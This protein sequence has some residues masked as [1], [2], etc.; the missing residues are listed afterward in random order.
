MQYINSYI[1]LVMKIE[2]EARFDI[3]FKNLKIAI[4]HAYN[5][6]TCSHK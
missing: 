6:Y 3:Y 5:G 1:E 4:N 2:K